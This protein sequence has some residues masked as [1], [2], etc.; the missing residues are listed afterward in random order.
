MQL[1]RTGVVLL[2]CM[3]CKSNLELARWEKCGAMSDLSGTDPDVEEHCQRTVQ[4]SAGNT[5]VY[6]TFGVKDGHADERLVR[7]EEQTAAGYRVAH[8]PDGD[9]HIDSEQRSI[10]SPDGGWLGTE[11]TDFVPAGTPARRFRQTTT[12]DEVV[13]IEEA[14][15]DGG[16]ELTNE[17]TSAR[18]H[19]IHR[20][21]A[22]VP[23]H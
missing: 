4:A 22:P 7:T 15:A 9:G 19:P 10:F 23:A 21:P 16:W 20:Q 13:T 6:R 2:L 11:T 3:G 17:T 1:T 18:R 12:D 14:W 5:L 8:D